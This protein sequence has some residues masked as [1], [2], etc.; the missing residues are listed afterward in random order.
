MTI[1]ESKP[2]LPTIASRNGIDE[3]RTLSMS[4]RTRQLPTDGLFEKHLSPLTRRRQ[5][6]IETR[7]LITRNILQNSTENRLN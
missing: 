7:P 5:N 2:I 4:I 3:I 6:Q 1:I